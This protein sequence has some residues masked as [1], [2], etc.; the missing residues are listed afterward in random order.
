MTTTVEIDLNVR[1]ANGTFAGLEDCNGPV[2]VGD[3]VNV[4]EPESGAYG[5]ALVTSIDHEHR[6]V[7]LSLAWNTL[8]FPVD[9][10][11]LAQ[12]IKNNHRRSS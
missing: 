9:Y 4:L 5:G 2:E 10:H 6:L 8:Q 1:T 3:V 7:Y 12:Q 11:A